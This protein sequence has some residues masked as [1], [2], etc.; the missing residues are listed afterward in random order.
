MITLEQYVGVHEDS[1]DWNTER[2]EN[3]KRLLLAVNDLMEFAELQGVRFRKNPATCSQISGKTL[4]GFRPQNATQGA[5][6]S[7]HK[8]GKGIDLYDPQNEIDEWCMANQNDLEDFGIYIEHPSATR[9]WSHW[10]TRT[11]RSGNR[12]FMP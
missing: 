6:T 11:P 7:S 10:T 1:P 3:A 8:D 4:G 12:V 9:T 5:A 2:I